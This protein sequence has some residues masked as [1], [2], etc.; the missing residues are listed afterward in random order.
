MQRK[1]KVK[2]PILLIGFNR[3]EVIQRNIENLRQI[4]PH[5]LYITIDGPRQ[6]NETDKCLVEEVR[7]IVRNIDFCTDVEYRIHDVNRGG[8]YTICTGISWVLSKEETVIIVEDDVMAHESFFRFMDEMLNRYKDD[9]RI[10]MVSGCNYTPMPFP[11]KEDYCFCHSGHI[12]G[13]AT[14]RRAWRDFNANEVVKE[15]YLTDEFLNQISLTSGQKSH[16]RDFFKWLQQQEIGTISWDYMYAYYRLTR[17]LLSIVPKSH[18]TSNIGT[19]GWHIN[20]KEKGQFMKIDEEFI[21]ICHP[22]QVIWNKDYD[23]YHF[24]KWIRVS[25]GIRTKK[26]IKGALKSFYRRLHLIFGSKTSI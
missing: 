12:W 11:N 19:K 8:N 18:L 26:R 10:V 25:F 21:A 9:S 16:N 13:W 2:S 14:W 20:R 24:K 1:Y 7:A 22:A 23:K 5:K 15:E 17:Q 6:N 3:P 4:S